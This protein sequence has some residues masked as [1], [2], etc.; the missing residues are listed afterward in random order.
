MKRMLVHL[1][2]AADVPVDVFAVTLSVIFN[3]GWRGFVQYECGFFYFF[4]F[5][6][7]LVFG[8]LVCVHGF[9]FK[10]LL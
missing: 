10:E 1:K 6:S 5:L 3:P 7:S 2:V 8:L 9:S 4:I